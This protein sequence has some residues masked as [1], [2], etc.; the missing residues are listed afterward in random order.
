MPARST[1]GC[2]EPE[3][4]MKISL[5]QSRVALERDGLIALRDASGTRVVCEGGALWITQQ[6]DAADV[7]LQGGE[8][9]V[10]GHGG[11]T[12]VMAL[13]PSALRLLEPRAGFWRWLAG[14]IDKLTPRFPRSVTMS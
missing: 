13:R 3:T 2:P 5:Y 8:S 6:Q 11:L 7:V 1:E 12:L 4:K 14:W 10:V 9:L